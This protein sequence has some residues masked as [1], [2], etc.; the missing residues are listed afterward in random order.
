MR[1]DA[2]LTGDPHYLSALAQEPS[3]VPLLHYLY[4][5]LYL[6]RHWR[7]LTLFLRQAGAPL[8]NNIVE[9]SLK[10]AVAP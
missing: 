7:P 3:P 4:S 5:E 1:A 6:L 2:G 10:R 9:R 8:N